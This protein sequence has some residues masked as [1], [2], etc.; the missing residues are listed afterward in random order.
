MAFNEK[1]TQ[2]SCNI[3]DMNVIEDEFIFLFY[4]Y[5]VT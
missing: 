5:Y 2:Q 4:N 1:K 3:M